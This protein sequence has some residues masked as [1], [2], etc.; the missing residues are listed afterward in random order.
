MKIESVRAKFL[1]FVKVKVRSFVAANDDF[2]N[3]LYIANDAYLVRDAASLKDPLVSYKNEK[4]ILDGIEKLDITEKVIYFSPIN[5]FKIARL[6]KV[7]K[8]YYEINDPT[9][10]EFVRLVKK[11]N[12]AKADGITIFD[13]V[14]SLQVYKEKIPASDLIK[15]LKEAKILK[16]ISQDKLE[17]VISHS[18]IE[19]SKVKIFE[20]KIKICD[21]RFGCLNSP[22]FDL[23]YFSNVYK[24]NEK[25]DDY[26]LNK[27]FGYKM[28]IKYTKL[29]SH[30]KKYINLL[31]YYRYCYYYS[32]SGEIAYLDLK[33][34]LKTEISNI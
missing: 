30:Y 17:K 20:N 34:K 25:Q 5:G 6:I 26:L 23:A 33:N 29:L 24:L 1:K 11:M 13:P 2:S 32:L 9:I 22:F 8:V 10:L 14:K 3:T 21:F 15:P 16:A 7:S 18:F 28:K 19:K 4:R 31:R 12:K 27:Y